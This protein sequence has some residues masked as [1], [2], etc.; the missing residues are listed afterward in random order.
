MSPDE[1]KRVKEN[2]QSQFVVKFGL[3]AILIIV[4]APTI[5]LLANLAQ[6]YGTV[7]QLWVDSEVEKRKAEI[8][9]KEDLERQRIASS[10]SI[11]LRE[12]ENEKIKEVSDREIRRQQIEQEYKLELMRKQAIHDA[13]ERKRVIGG[14]SERIAVIDNFVTSSKLVISDLEF[15]MKQAEL[16][17][18][19]YRVSSLPDDK[20]ELA[21]DAL[22]IQRNTEL[23]K[24]KKIEL[25]R[26]VQELAGLTEKLNI[27]LMQR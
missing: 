6:I 20:I 12:L 8:A 7:S 13:E 2:A 26:S 3:V 16:R 10:E 24:S 21:R 23:V 1:L 25:D 15:K 19:D 18:I 22:L 27:A 11:R 14:L 4:L 17:M 5:G 9:S